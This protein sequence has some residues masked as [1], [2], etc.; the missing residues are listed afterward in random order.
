MG[1]FRSIAVKVDP[2]NLEPGVHYAE[3]RAVEAGQEWRG[4]VARVPVTVCIP[5]PPD[6]FNDEAAGGSGNGCAQKASRKLVFFSSSHPEN[7]PEY[8]N[9]LYMYGNLWWALRTPTSV[10]GKATRS[11]RVV[12]PE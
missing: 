4:P 11:L 2:T 8:S 1:F 7:S 12:T 10:Y 9:F 5:L 6:H 3:V